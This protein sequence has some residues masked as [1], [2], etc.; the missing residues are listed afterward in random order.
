MSLNID[1]LK[2]ALIVGVGT[3]VIG[4]LIKYLIE[5]FAKKE[6]H[7]LYIFIVILFLTGFL[8]HIICQFTGVNKWYCRHGSACISN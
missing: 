7:E 8:I 4:I 2:E 6:K 1:V 3:V 5:L